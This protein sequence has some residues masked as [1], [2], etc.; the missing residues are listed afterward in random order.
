MSDESTNLTTTLAMIKADF[1]ERALDCMLD[2][3]SL[4]PD[5]N[6]LSRSVIALMLRDTLNATNP[7]ML[8]AKTGAYRAI[9]EALTPATKRAGTTL[10][11]RDI[12]RE[13]R[14]RELGRRLNAKPRIVEDTDG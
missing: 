12:D 2:E 4:M 5:I 14:E 13:E 10:D 8:N 11:S 1:N 6:K 7:Q 9:L 3:L